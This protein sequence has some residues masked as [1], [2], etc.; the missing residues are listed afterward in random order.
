MQ[1]I[2]T[3][4]NQSKIFL[5]YAHTPDALKNAILSLREHFQKKITV[6]FGCGG[7]RDKSK[8]SLMGKVAKKYCDK[9]S[10]IFKGAEQQ[11]LSTN[12]FMVDATLSI[13]DM[14]NGKESG[15]SSIFIRSIGKTPKPNTIKKILNI[16]LYFINFLFNNLLAIFLS[17]KY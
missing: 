3:L 11:W 12:R 16:N 2:R 6:I 9:I 5:D 15:K 1:L 14:I 8:R 17:L 13:I 7:E 4:P 10:L